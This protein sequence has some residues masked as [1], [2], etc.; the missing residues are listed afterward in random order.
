MHPTLDVLCT[1]GR[2]ST[3]RVWDMRT[4]QQIFALVGHQG[5]VNT[6]QCQ[7]GEPQVMTG[8]SD[9]T[10]RLWDLATG[11]TVTTLTHHKKTVRALLVHPNEYTFASASTDSIKQ[12]KSP[13]GAFIQNLNGHKGIIN[14]MAINQDNV[15]VSGGF[16]VN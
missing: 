16:F 2:D 13:D 1:G 6:V 12:Y 3:C 10:I 7:S 9:S 8:S 4:K 15:L 5:T 14:T 11:K